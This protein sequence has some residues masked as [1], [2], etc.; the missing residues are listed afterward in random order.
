MTV[1]IIGAG[2]AGCF[3]G[4]KIKWDDAIIF[5][6][7]TKIGEPV[8]CTGIITD[9]V[10]NILK[11]IPP[12][13]IVNEID[14][15]RIRAPNGESIDVDLSHKD[16]IFDRAGFD[17][18]CGGLAEDHGTE[19]RMNHGFKNWT[20]K[21]NR[22]NLNFSNGKSTM[23]DYVVGSDGPFSPVARKAGMYGQRQMLTGFQARVETKDKLFESNVTDIFFGLGEFA[24]IVPENN[25]TARI[26]II[27]G[28]KQNFDNLIKGYRYIENQSGAIPLFN[29]NQKIQQGNV[30]L[31]GDAAT[32][33]K[34]T[35]YGGILYGLMAGEVLGD[36]WYGYEK[37]INK[38]IKKELWLSKKMREILNKLS[39]KDCNE[40]ISLFAKEKNKK[41][42]ESSDR[43]FPSKFAIKMVINE[44]RLLKYALKAF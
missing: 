30:A 33:V 27:G 24:W 23:V 32:H 9:S 25:K 40:L 15:F 41:I 39:D 7:K 42:L 13:T 35:T 3:L 20:V 31:I 5:D 21:D 44:P 1:G 2:P 38:K 18:F 8:Q 37:R 16:I 29:P 17:K 43:N 34:P 12:S 22:F 36:S 19:I 28:D 6:N 10:H 11:K 4:S 26:G 14:T